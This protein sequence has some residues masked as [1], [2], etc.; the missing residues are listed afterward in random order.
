MGAPLDKWVSDMA[1][2]AKTREEASLSHRQLFEGIW[3]P[4]ENVVFAL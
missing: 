4:V 2:D 1:D 3:R